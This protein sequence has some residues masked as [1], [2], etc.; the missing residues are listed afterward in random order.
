M[1]RKRLLDPSDIVFKLSRLPLTEKQLKLLAAMIGKCDL[2]TG[3]VDVS[4]NR[5]AKDVGANNRHSVH[6]MLSKLVLKGYAQKCGYQCYLLPFVADEFWIR[7]KQR[8]RALSP[9][10]VKLVRGLQKYKV[11]D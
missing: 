3:R 10:I 9:E 1:A 7:E 8:E 11:N 6:K 2:S 4:L 5:L